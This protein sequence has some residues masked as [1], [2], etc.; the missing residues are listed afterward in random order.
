MRFT[1]FHAIHPTFSTVEKP[2]FHS[3][4][5]VRVAEIEV[6]SIY[7][8]F[9]VTQHMDRAWTTNPQ[10]VFVYYNNRGNRSTSVGDIAVDENNVAHLC[11]PFGWSVL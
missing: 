10:V 3:K 2:N 9:R 11:E 4:D 6:D 1:I 5:F 8:V 7:D